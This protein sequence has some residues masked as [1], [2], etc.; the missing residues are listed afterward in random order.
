MKNFFSALA[1]VFGF[2]IF[3]PIILLICIGYLLYLPFDI[4]QYHKMPYYKD[5]KVKY[6]FLITARDKV[7]LYNRIV[8]EKLPIEHV[9]YND[10]EYFLKDNQVLLCDWTNEDFDL[11]NNEWV[12]H[13]DDDH[14][15]TYTKT[16]EDALAEEREILN[17]EHKHL[18]IKFL[19]FYSDITD[20]EKFEKAKECPYFYPIFSVEEDI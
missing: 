18:P 20:A 6:S 7:K 19:F 2:I 17:P 11:V 8:K 13:L 9:K 16:M 3:I 10:F 4:I 5:F 12:F 1:S 15:D 14:G